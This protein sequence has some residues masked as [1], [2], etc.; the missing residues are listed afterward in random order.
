MKYIIKLNGDRA[1]SDTIGAYE[2]L[3]IQSSKKIKT[4]YLELIL[5]ELDILIKEC[6]FLKKQV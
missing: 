3:Q 5:V 2:P 6:G 1:Y 4:D